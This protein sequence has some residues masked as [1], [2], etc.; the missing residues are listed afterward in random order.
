MI[1]TV[2]LLIPKDK[3]Q[4]IEGVSNWEL[5]SKTDTYQ[6]FIRNPT[7][8]EKATGKYFPRLTGYKRRFGDDANV[9]I[10]FSV[11]KLLLLNNLDEVSEKDFP[12]IVSILYD[13][14][15]EMGV[16]VGKSVLK[17]AKVSSV[18]YSKNIHL[19]D[20]FTASYVISEIN[21]ISVRKSFDFSKA[22][23]A[24][25][26]QSLYIHATN[27]QFVI[28]DKIADLIKK[29]KRALDKDQTIYQRSLFDQI[30]NRLTEV[31]RL[32][33]RLNKKQK[34]NEVL[35]KNG[36]NK[37]P[38]FSDVFSRKISQKVVCDYWQTLIKGN[39]LAVL[40]LDIKPKDLLNMLMRSELKPKPVRAVYLVGLHCLAKDSNG[41]RQLRSILEKKST[42]RSWYRMSNDLK[43]LG[44]LV[45][46]DYLRDWV[47]QIDQK[48]K[49]YKTLKTLDYERQKKNT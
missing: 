26:G 32:E 38:T 40:S 41:T 23:F 25:D 48:L 46:E 29:K 24:N 35:L 5:Y 8:V 27:H 28:Y 45:S 49:D 21:K 47:K 19:T 18:H 39:N 43:E 34:M 30:D 36:G 42:D 10:E 37:D 2:C 20:G 14:M 22:R 44:R 16:V 6:K 12:L 3:M 17:N 4:F 13:R 31:L 9:R 7:K 1:D 33:V 15:S 11:P